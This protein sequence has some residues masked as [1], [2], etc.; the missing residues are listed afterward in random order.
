[1]AS[2]VPLDFVGDSQD[3]QKKKRDAAGDFGDGEPEMISR[4]IVHPDDELQHRK[5]NE[6]NASAHGGPHLL[7][8]S[9][10][11]SRPMR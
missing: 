2:Y 5:E 4:Q 8:Y 10:I 7:T 1:M 6:Y 3:C 9:A 11:A